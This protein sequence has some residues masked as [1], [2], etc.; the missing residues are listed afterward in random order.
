MNLR[1]FYA[2]HTANMLCKRLLIHCSCFFSVC[3]SR[4]PAFIFFAELFGAGSQHS[5]T[6]SRNLWQKIELRFETKLISF[7][8]LNFF[9]CNWP[10]KIQYGDRNR[11]NIFQSSWIRDAANRPRDQTVNFCGQNKKLQNDRQKAPKKANH[12]RRMTSSGEEIHFLFE[13]R[14]SDLTLNFFQLFHKRAFACSVSPN[15][16][17]CSRLAVKSVFFSS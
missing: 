12:Q 5:G 11:W 8:W 9:Q 10:L 14:S 2:V 4:F 1:Y 13:L 15:G 16:R 17:V 7:P 6:A 3:L